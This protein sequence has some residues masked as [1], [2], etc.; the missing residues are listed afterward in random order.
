VTIFDSSG[1]ATLTLFEQAAEEFFN[2]LSEHITVLKS[3]P[4]GEAKI[5][6]VSDKVI[7]K[8]F[9][10]NIRVT[11]SSFRYISH[12]CSSSYTADSVEWIPKP[13][14]LNLQS[15]LPSTVLAGTSSSQLKI[16]GKKNFLIQALPL[17]PHPLIV[18]IA[19]V[20]KLL[21]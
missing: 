2:V 1:R 12:M 4:N 15:S 8:H 11:S 16:T 20:V 5:I 14:T 7:D 6:A 10:F 13:F 17:A 3:E 19:Q 21:S 9:I 18:Q